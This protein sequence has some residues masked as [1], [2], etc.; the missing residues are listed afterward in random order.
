MALRIESVVGKVLVDDKPATAGQMVSYENCVS[1]GS[2]GSVCIYDGE[3]LAATLASASPPAAFA[4][5]RATAASNGS[6][7]LVTYS[8]P[9]LD[10]NPLYYRRSYRSQI[11]TP[12][13]SVGIRV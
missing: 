10:V 3:A 12:G 5:S 6:A 1:V 2:D 11:R 4:L 8:P 13:G 7:R 9:T